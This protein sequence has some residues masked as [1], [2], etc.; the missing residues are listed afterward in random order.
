MICYK[1]DANSYYLMAGNAGPPMVVARAVASHST[2]SH[3]PPTQSGS[4]ESKKPHIT[5]PVPSKAVPTPQS[6]PLRKVVGSNA[7]RKGSDRDNDTA[8]EKHMVRYVFTNLTIF[9]YRECFDA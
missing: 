3:A 6:A 4:A 7:G 5:P 1:L 2:P 9:Q 8:E